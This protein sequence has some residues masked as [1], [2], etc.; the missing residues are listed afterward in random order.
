MLRSLI[1]RCSPGPLILIAI[2]IAGLVF[3]QEAVRGEMSA[4]LKGLLGEVGAQGVDAMLVGASKPHEGIVATILGVGLLVFAAIGVVV[5]LKDALNTVWDVE[6]PPGSGIWHFA[7]TYLVSL[8]G[9]LSLGFLLL[10]SLLITAALA[11]GGKYVA[12]YLPEAAVH[13]VSLAISFAIITVLFAMMFKWLPD[14]PVAWRDVWLGA[15]VTAA[16]F[17]IGKFLD[18]ALYRQ[19]RPGVR[20]MGRRPRLSCC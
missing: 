8:A 1:I 9:V 11:A 14:T 2:A 15:A 20:L 12:P 17:D 19:A 13:L 16:L 6:A 7:R 10:V 18:R 5:Q 4:Q 3:G